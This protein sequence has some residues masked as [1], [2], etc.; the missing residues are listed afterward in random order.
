MMSD[1]RPLSNLNFA[2]DIE[3][4]MLEWDEDSLY[5]QCSELL[6]QSRTH[7]MLREFSECINVCNQGI[8]DCS[9]HS[10]DKLNCCFEGFVILA[11]QAYGEQNLWREVLPFI[12]AA[13]G[14]IQKCP[15]TIIKLCIGLLSWVGE[16]SLAQKQACLW[17]E[18]SSNKWNMEQHTDVGRVVLEK[19][20]IP[21][22]RYN[23]IHS[24]LEKLDGMMDLEKDSIRKWIDRMHIAMDQ[25][26]MADKNDEAATKF[27]KEI[28]QSLLLTIF[29][30]MRNFLALIPSLMKHSVGKAVFFGLSFYFVFLH[31]KMSDG[32]F[33]STDITRTLFQIYSQHFK[34]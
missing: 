12:D 23:E 21:Q 17:L 29:L 16:H 6:H 3:R 7:L 25:R 33:A 14:G 10:P 4:D 26:R 28:S 1:F 22:K 5:E 32:I 15:P 8:R 9:K 18:E 13:Y 19:V 20:L 2:D 11:I 24:M 27:R 31:L 34:K 30:R